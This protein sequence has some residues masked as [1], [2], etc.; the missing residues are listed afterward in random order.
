MR[1]EGEATR[2]ACDAAVDDAPARA[3]RVTQ[4]ATLSPG[5]ARCLGLAWFASRIVVVAHDAVDV[6]GARPRSD[7]HHRPGRRPGDACG[8]RGLLAPVGVPRSGV[9]DT[10]VTNRWSLRTR[11]PAPR[12]D[13]TPCSIV[14]R[15]TGR[16]ERLGQKTLVPPTGTGVQCGRFR[17][18]VRARDSFH[19]IIFFQRTDAITIVGRNE[20]GGSV[21]GGVTDAAP[22]AAESSRDHCDAMRRPGRD[23]WSQWRDAD[24]R[25]PAP[26]SRRDGRD[27]A[28]RRYH[29]RCSRG[30]RGLRR[31]GGRRRAPGGGLR[32]DLRA[33]P[34]VVRRRRV[35]GLSG[36]GAGERRAARWFG[37]DAAARRTATQYPDHGDRPVDWRR[38]GRHPTLGSR[39]HRIHRRLPRPR[40]HGGRIS[41]LGDDGAAKAGPTDARVAVHACVRKCRRLPVASADGRGPLSQSHAAVLL[42]RLFHPAGGARGG[43]QR[44][45]AVEP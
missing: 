17:E 14:S 15:A 12:A 33:A 44:R 18:S 31:R 30:L 35:R 23:R 43:E 10:F 2:T 13:Q 28:T 3:R 7:V 6:R 41:H 25:P 26:A 21:V 32:G 19:D 4:P 40:G 36:R 39:R 9:F 22:H 20:E 11:R 45:V 38:A 8:P 27:A 24:V 37:V 42:C 16:A 1:G 5:I 34:S 29:P